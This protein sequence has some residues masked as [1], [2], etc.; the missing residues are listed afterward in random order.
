MSSFPTSERSLVAWWS[1]IIHSPFSCNLFA[2]SLILRHA[3]VCGFLFP[4]K[5][6][7]IRIPMDEYCSCPCI[8]SWSIPSLK[9][10]SSKGISSHTGTDTFL[11]AF[12]KSIELITDTPTVLHVWNSFSNMHDTVNTLMDQTFNGHSAWPCKPW[13]YLSLYSIHSYILVSAT[14]R[15]SPLL[16]WRGL[17]L[18]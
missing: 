7:S 4:K 6:R 17:L 8:T 9:I 3:M 15:C 13:P 5:E 1:G 12:N 10:V 14:W 11:Y 18:K 16:A 2:N